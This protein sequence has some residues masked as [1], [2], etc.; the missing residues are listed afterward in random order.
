MG[1][2]EVVRVGFLAWPLHR[3]LTCQ[4]VRRPSTEAAL[5]FPRLLNP[6]N[7]HQLMYL[8]INDLAYGTVVQENRTNQG[9]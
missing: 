5:E 4:E 9:R 3:V 2:D 8:L 7:L 1:L 6:Q